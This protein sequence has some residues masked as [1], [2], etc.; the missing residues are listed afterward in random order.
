MY[1]F[2]GV[3]EFVEVIETGSFSAAAR[4]LGKSK[5]YVSQRV[6]QLED[7][8]DTR[9]LQR[10]TRKL[11]LTDAGEIYFRYAKSVAAQLGEGEERV[12]DFQHSL[13]GRIR[14]S[15]V[16]GGLG[17]WYLAPALARF[18]ALH[19]GVNIEL[20]LSSRLVDLVAEGFDFTIRVGRLE[21]SSMMARKLTSIRY[22]LYASPAYLKSQGII[23]HPEQLQQHNCLTGATNRWQFKLD[24]NVIEVK[25]HGSWHSKSGQALI[26]AAREGVGVVRTANFYAKEAL[27]RGEVVELLT[28]WT[29]EKTRV[30]IIYPSGR[31]LPQRV[32]AAIHFLL[33]EFRDHDYL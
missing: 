6:S 23:T 4:K 33:D 13:T 27:A 16:D 2:H 15:I 26:A 22:G 24:G 12:R 8:L 20:D 25:P 11:S 18:A 19:P 9:L 3:L 30:W 32:T 1:R 14:V 28:D 31:H 5:A 7:R 29:R 21:D 10:T 17:E